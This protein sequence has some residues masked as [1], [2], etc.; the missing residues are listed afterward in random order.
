MHSKYSIRLRGMC[1]IFIIM[2]LFVLSGCSFVTDSMT[3]DEEILHVSGN[4]YEIIDVDRRGIFGSEKSLIEGVVN[5]ANKFAESRNK[6]ANPLAARVHRVG[7]A[8]DWAWFYYK[9]E[10]VDKNTPEAFRTLTDITIV[11]DPRLSAEFWVNRNNPETETKN[12]SDEIL[13]L[14]EL[15][16]K[17]LLTDDEFATQKK[18]LLESR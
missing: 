15:R 9:F 16:K 14:D 4:I 13:K 6:A 1:S 3:N 18:K 7:I 10:L 2:S 8:A 12:V 11:R 5:M 17:G